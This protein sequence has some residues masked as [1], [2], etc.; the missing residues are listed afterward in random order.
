MMSQIEPFWR[1]AHPMTERGFPTPGEYPCAGW[2]LSATVA[3]FV[4]GGVAH[5]AA[6]GPAER[7]GLPW[8]RVSGICCFVRKGPKEPSDARNRHT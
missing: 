1:P 6:L 3:E 8:G 4:R 7:P 5:S 2:I